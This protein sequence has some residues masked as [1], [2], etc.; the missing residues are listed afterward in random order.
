MTSMVHGKEE[1]KGFVAR[2]IQ[3]CNDKGVEIESAGPST[4][5]EI[6][7]LTEVPTA[8]DIFEAV[9][10]ERLARELADKRTTEARKSSLLLTPRSP[11]ITCLT[12]WPRTI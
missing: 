6:T 2:R 7:G 10:D 5:V 12:R 3:E 11:W 9:E 4:P 8:G 1:G